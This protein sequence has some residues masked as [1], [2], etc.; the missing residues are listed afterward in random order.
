METAK[1]NGGDLQ[2]W[3]ADT[4]AGIPVYKTTRAYDMLPWNQWSHRL[5][6]L[7]QSDRRRVSSPAFP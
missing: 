4:I 7:Y 5:H 6:R 2:I 1:L 3:F